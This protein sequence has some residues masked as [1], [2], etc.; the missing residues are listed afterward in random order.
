MITAI[1]LAFFSYKMSNI[2]SSSHVI[3]SDKQARFLANQIFLTIIIGLLIKFLSEYKTNVFV[4][5][6]NSLLATM[7]ILSCGIG[8]CV[9]L[10]VSICFTDVT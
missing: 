10:V 8:L 3:V 4:F 2:V 6:K 7:H 9:P 5:K 1:R